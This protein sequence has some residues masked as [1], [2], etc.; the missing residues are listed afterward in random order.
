[1]ISTCATCQAHWSKH[2]R[3]C[4]ACVGSIHHSSCSL[5]G[6]HTN[7]NV[8][9]SN[10]LQSACG[11]MGS[12][13]LRT[14]ALQRPAS[15]AHLVAWFH[16]WAFDEEFGEGTQDCSTRIK[17]HNQEHAELVEA[18]E[19]RAPGGVGALD[20]LTAVAHE[21]ADVVWVAYGTAHSLGIPLDAV[22]RALSASLRTRTNADGSPAVRSDGKVTKGVN[23]RPPTADIRAILE[24]ALS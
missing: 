13:T 5:M 15:P 19:S 10:L 12:N 20:W 7:N 23:Y 14:P 16:L 18:L 17:L 22:L 6:I 2:C 9:L 8:L 1:M 3:K 11:G 24:E 21:L 4:N